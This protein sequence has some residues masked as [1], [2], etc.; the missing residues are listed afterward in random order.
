MYKSNDIAE[1]YPIRRL[2]VYMVSNLMILPN[3]SILY[4]GLSVYI[5]SKSHDIAEQFILYMLYGGC[6]CM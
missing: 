3:S 1:Q 4:G 5:I 2:S 6:R